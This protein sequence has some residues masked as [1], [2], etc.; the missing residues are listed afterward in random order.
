MYYEHVEVPVCV[1]SDANF[2]FGYRISGDADAYSMFPS[3]TYD[4]GTGKWSSASW[5]LGYP[6]YEQS[7]MWGTCSR[8]GQG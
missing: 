3:T 5:T 6:N 1:G 7:F 4:S 8:G 2:Q